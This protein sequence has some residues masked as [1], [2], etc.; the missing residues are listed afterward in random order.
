MSSPKLAHILVANLYFHSSVVR[1]VCILLC[2]RHGAFDADPDPC[3]V[4]PERSCCQHYSRE[5]PDPAEGTNFTGKFP[6]I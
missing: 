5:I 6:L 1:S 3:R 2:W 4:Y